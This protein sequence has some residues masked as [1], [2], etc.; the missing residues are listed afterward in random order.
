MHDM[1]LSGRR[2]KKSSPA[3]FMKTPN[4]YKRSKA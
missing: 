3:R 1:Y 2:Q 4:W